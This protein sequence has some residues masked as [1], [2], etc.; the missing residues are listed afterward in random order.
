[1]PIKDVTELEVYQLAL[2]LLKVTYRLAKVVAKEDLECA[3]Q[4]KK[5]ASQIAPLIAEG[6]GKKSSPSE[7]KRFQVMAMGTSDEMITHIRQA[8]IICLSVNKKSCDIL[9]EQYLILSKRLNVL[10]KNWK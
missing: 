7:F 5:T 4:L 6:Y 3:K 10:I 2:K 9:E 1:M 8:K